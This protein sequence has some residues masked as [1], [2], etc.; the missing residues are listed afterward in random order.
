VTLVAGPTTLP[1][2]AN[3]ERI[4]VQSAADMA[5]AVLDRVPSCDV[6]IAVAAVADYAPESVSATK[7]KKTGAPMTI[8]LKPTVDILAAVAA[9]KDAPYCV[10]F[11]A[12]SHDIAKH[13]EEKRQRK[14]VPLIVANRAQDA[15]GSDDNEVVLFD[16]AGEHPLPKMDKLAL[17]RALVQEIAQRL[18]K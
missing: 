1:T 11:A 12:E 18:A 14:K 2:P 6:F 16:D 10:G 5:K 13:A 8:I 3:V 7:I 15:F 17:A 4:D 9:R